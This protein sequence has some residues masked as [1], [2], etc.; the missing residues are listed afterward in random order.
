[1]SDWNGAFGHRHY[2]YS[3]PAEPV[4]PAEPLSHAIKGRHALWANPEP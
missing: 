2:L 4:E 3:A 1:M